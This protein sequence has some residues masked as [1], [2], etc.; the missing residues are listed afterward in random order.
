[1]VDPVNLANVKRGPSFAHKVDDPAAANLGLETS[2]DE[3]LDKTPPL[4][5]YATRLSTVL[6]IRKTGDVLFIE[7]DVWLSGT[8]PKPEIA[9][10]KDASHE[11]KFRFHL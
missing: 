10:H 1:M 3:Q 6:L 11:R 7:R 4:N 9:K 2:V 5:Y 8:D